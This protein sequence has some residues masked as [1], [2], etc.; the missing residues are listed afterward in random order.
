MCG[1]ALF[2]ILPAGAASQITLTGT[3]AHNCTIN[4]TPSAGASG[5]N[6]TDGAQHVA[7]GSI[8][9]SCNKKAGY[10]IVVTSANCTTPAPTG[11][12][13][14]GTSGGEKLGY[15]VESQNPTTGGRVSTVTGLLA[16]NCTG[17]NAR[18][19]TN[20]KVTGE[21]SN[22][23]VNFSGNAALSADTYQDTITF[24]MN[25]N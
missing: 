6:L 7:V 18:A 3:V 9:Q 13:L 24:T 11:A 17:Q 15:S 20:A 12:K 16:S 10:T 23:F 14:V 5:L 1:G 19:V 2:H 25:V 21:V 22:I 8:A 4:V